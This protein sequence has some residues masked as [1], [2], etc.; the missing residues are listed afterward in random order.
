MLK[1]LMTVT[2]ALM[3]S[4]VHAE[5]GLECNPSDVMC[6]SES[7]LSW[8]PKS[9][10]TVTMASCRKVYSQPYA[11]YNKKNWKFMFYELEVISTINNVEGK[12][13]HFAQ[14]IRLR[15]LK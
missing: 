13:R 2:I 11:N 5:E 1:V 14:T 8:V 10:G 12:E 4:Q 7:C 15:D 6:M 9:I 3:M